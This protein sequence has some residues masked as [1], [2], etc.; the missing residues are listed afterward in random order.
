MCLRVPVPVLHNSDVKNT[1]CVENQVEGNGVCRANLTWFLFGCSHCLLIP[2]KSKYDRFTFIDLRKG[3][4][5]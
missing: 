3:C 4:A 1:V 2:S 5:C